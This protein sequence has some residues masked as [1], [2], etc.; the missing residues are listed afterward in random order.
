M[1]AASTSR[2]RFLQPEDVTAVLINTLLLNLCSEHVDLRAHA[3]DLLCSLVLSNRLE[4]FEDLIKCRGE[5][6]Y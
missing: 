4:G 6:S 1:K 2:E 5:S 3:H